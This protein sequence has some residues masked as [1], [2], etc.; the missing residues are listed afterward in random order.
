MA[1]NHIEN[2]QYQGSAQKL[3]HILFAKGSVRLGLLQTDYV[4]CFFTIPKVYLGEMNQ[5]GL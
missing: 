1:S 2:M 5:I 4:N 3:I